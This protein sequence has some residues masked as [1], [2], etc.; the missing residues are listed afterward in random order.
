M[1]VTIVFVFVVHL[2]LVT[3]LV[4]AHSPSLVLHPVLVYGLVL[5]H[6]LPLFGVYC[7]FRLLFLVPFFSFLF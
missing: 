2:V 7:L 4:F 5:V 6:I 3:V 1:V